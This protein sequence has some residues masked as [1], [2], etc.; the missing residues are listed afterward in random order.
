MYA[1][2]QLEKKT[3][4]V[5]RHAKYSQLTIDT[6]AKKITFFINLF[7]IYFTVNSQVPL[8][9]NLINRYNYFFFSSNFYNKST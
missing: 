8:I 2:K 4:E 6:L 5:M 1:N 7:R 9:I 3:Q